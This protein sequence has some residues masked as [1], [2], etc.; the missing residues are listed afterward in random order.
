MYKLDASEK[1]TH[2]G[3][4]YFIRIRT[5]DESNPVVLF[6]H[7]GCG[8]PD[9]AQVMKYQSELSDKFTLVAWDQRGAGLAYN[10]TEA[11]N[12]I[13]TKDVYVNDAHNVIS[14]LKARFNKQ[15]III[16][17]HSFGSVLGVWIS[18][19]YPESI[20]AYV[21]IG[22]CVD[23][24]ENELLSYQWTLKETENQKDKRSVSILQKIG[25]P[26]DGIY[27]DNKSLM[28]QRAILHKLGGA[29]YA[30]R[31]PYWQELLFH[32]VPIMLKEYSISQLIKY[33]KGLSYSPSQPIAR[34]NPDFNN[35]AT[36]LDVP[37][38]LTLGRHD[39]NCVS[40]LAEEW[41]N[42][43]ECHDKKL[44]WF[45]NSAHSPQWEESENWNKQF[46]NL[47]K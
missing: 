39:Y 18:Q 20:A 21:G 47:F 13:I 2:N 30:N 16:V 5:Q 23:Y 25:P 45:E 14:Y 33:I 24:I 8:S 17:G 38:Y 6:I 12:L 29:T 42:K 22:Q 40:T 4:T 27:T 44:I 19:K 41:Y 26:N 1:I 28:K 3:Q 15:K 36:K 10:K 37:V 11:K 32:D 46:R 9:R 7:G 35:T 31:K 34:T 43:L